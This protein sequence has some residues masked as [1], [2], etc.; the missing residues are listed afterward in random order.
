MAE[1]SVPESASGSRLER[2]I[3]VSNFTVRP[4]V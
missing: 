1:T 2:Y 3:G 4:G